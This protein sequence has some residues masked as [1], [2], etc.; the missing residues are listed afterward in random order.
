M[1]P[2]LVLF[3]YIYSL[4]CLYSRGEIATTTTTT[5]TVKIQFPFFKRDMF[6]VLHKTDV[7][8]VKGGSGVEKKGLC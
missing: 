6:V 8:I 3:H 1:K 5:T 4:L 7:F 2:P